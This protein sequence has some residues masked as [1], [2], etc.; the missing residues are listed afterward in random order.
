MFGNEADT[1]NK[2]IPKPLSIS[3]TLH[4]WLIRAFPTRGIE[5]NFHHIGALEKSKSAG[6]CRFGFPWVAGEKSNF[7]MDVAADESCVKTLSAGQRLLKLVHKQKTKKKLLDL[8]LHEMDSPLDY[9]PLVAPFTGTWELSLQALSPFSS[10]S[11]LGCLH[12]QRKL[13][14]LSVS[15]SILISD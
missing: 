2:G 14:F 12:A 6:V 13:V 4:V 7:S 10:Y 3:I 11:G 8:H 5:V 15:L 1:F 9:F